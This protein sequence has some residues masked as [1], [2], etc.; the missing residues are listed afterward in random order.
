MCHRFGSLPNCVG[1]EGESCG[2]FWLFGVLVASPVF[3]RVF[4]VVQVVKDLFQMVAAE[5]LDAVE[6]AFVADFDFA[7]AE[8]GDGLGFVP[9][10]EFA[11]HTASRWNVAVIDRLMTEPFP[12]P[13]AFEFVGNTEMINVDG[14]FAVAMFAIIVIVPE[15]KLVA[16][17][18][19]E[20][21]INKRRGAG[22]GNSTSSGR[23]NRVKT[24]SGY[25]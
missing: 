21:A 15:I 7:D 25:P 16:S 23:I 14:I 6:D 19:I 17:V 18:V 20:K 10:G 24:S 1:G 2:A 5:D 12:N 4:R 22:F 11:W 9:Q 8:V 13:T 3:V